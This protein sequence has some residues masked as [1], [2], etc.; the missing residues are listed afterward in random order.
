MSDAPRSLKRRFGEHFPDPGKDLRAGK[1]VKER[2]KLWREWVRSEIE[3]Q[4][5]TRREKAL[6]WARHRHFR[7]GRQWISSRDGRTWREPNADE[8]RVRAVL[9]L[10]G[11]ALDFRLGL[12]TEQR[13][14]W[15]HTPVPGAGV[16]A[17]ET[18]EAQQS[19]VEWY[20][21]RDRLWRLFGVVFE[22][23]QTDGC[24]FIHTLIDPD[25]GP[26][27]ED[28]VLLPPSDERF[29]A[30]L[31]Q[32][33][34]RNDEGLL[35][36]PRAE[37]GEILPPSAEPHR[38]QDGDLKFRALL[39]H[40][41]LA[42]PEAKTIN[43]PLDP[44]RWF[45]VRR[46]IDVE[47]ARAEADDDSIEPDVSNIRNDP[48][49]S[50]HHHGGPHF[51]RGLPPYPTSREEIR[52]GVESYL[53]YLPASEEFGG[54]AWRR[55]IGDRLIGGADELPGKVIPVSRVT[56]GATDHDLYPRPVMADWIP[57]QM[58]VNAVLSALITHVKV[59]GGGRLI[60]QRGT[61]VTETLTN[62][63]ASLVEY[64]GIK[65]DELRAQRVSGDVW[66]FLVF[67]IRQLENKTGH[68]DLARG[69]VT[70]GGSFQDITGRAILGARELFERQFG[71]MVRS[72]ADGLSEW[73]DV[74][75][76]LARW[77]FKDS[78]RLIPMTGRPDLAKRIDAS[79]LEGP[80]SV[81]VD[82]ETLQPLPRALRNQMLVD[83]LDR[84]LITVEEFQKRAPYADVRNVHM[85]DVDHWRRAQWV[86]TVLE[87]RWAELI[88]REPE[89]LLAPES[90]IAVLWQ[91]DPKAH[92]RALNEIVLDDRQP[93]PLRKLASDRWQIY[94][95]LERAKAG[96]A[97]IPP[98]VMGGP[99]IEPQEL[100]ATG[101]VQ[102]NGGVPGG[103][104]SALAAPTLSPTGVPEATGDVA[105]A[106]GELGVEEQV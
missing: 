27:R 69:M 4:K 17:R 81:F 79:K 84:G 24:A 11:P 30:L 89:E 82:P 59:W 71:P 93:W 48:L 33:Y 63:A 12:L 96:V 7:Q 68:T 26:E 99:E 76:R 101:A 8:N 14:G 61:V 62:F 43:G 91:D 60:A 105:E 53:I 64:E 54:G 40:E 75:V 73:A 77:L 32:G 29:E 92:K 74:T 52:D 90:G 22:A 15:R 31:A 104:P 88:S 85:G 2:G 100:A 98:E 36:L 106:L 39:A 37:E 25:A 50:A 70:G 95:D 21:Q 97:P 102:G 86:N 19:V 94:D 35:V 45:V 46:V 80:T 56:D 9:N 41:T 103:E 78:P 34:E 49:H 23:A 57:D 20:Y 51:Q 44:A 65:P 10:V 67:M 47:R 58:V 3:R 66:E 28:V 83:L 16:A 42:D 5:G 6:H 1:P 38:F 87:E 13:P 72:A 55:V 18:A